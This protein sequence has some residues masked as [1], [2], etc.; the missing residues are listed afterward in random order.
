MK[1]APSILA[2]DLSRLGE[3]IQ[4]V[5][6]GGADW[7]HVDVM[8]GHFV[9][10][11]TIGPVV[12]AGARRAT[13]LP[14]DV[15]LMISNPDDYVDDFV[16]AGADWVTVHAEACTHLHRTLARIGE[17]GAKAGVALNPATPLS[18]IEDVVEHLDLLLIMSVNP[19]FGGQSYIPRSSDKL[20]RARAMLDAAGSSAELQVDGGVGLSNIAEVAATGASVIVAGS[21]VYG[22][23]E[24]ATAGVSA[25]RSAASTG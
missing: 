9:P 22:Y 21:A 17:L 11:I 7:I 13:D 1:I 14:L 18:A 8:D 20:R 4:A 3:E 19:G 23:P 6:A 2:A 12:T 24:G 16:K 25:L 10:N 5:E 15:H